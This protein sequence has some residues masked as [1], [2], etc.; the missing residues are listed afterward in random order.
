MV[1]MANAI[2][3]LATLL[4][5]PSDVRYA[6]NRDGTADVQ[7]RMMHWPQKHLLDTYN[8][9]GTQVLEHAPLTTLPETVRLQFDWGASERHGNANE[10]LK[11]RGGMPSAYSGQYLAKNAA[12]MLKGAAGRMIREFRIRGWRLARISLNLRYDPEFTESAY[13]RRVLNRARLAK[14]ETEKRRK[15]GKKGRKR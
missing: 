11:K 6:N 7:V 3:S 4:G 9:F 14:E 8:E 15:R 13:K 10:Y 5:H 2:R 12:S 1:G